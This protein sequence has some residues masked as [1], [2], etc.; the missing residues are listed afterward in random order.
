ME[1]GR[2][3]PTHPEAEGEPV[4]RFS[5]VLPVCHGGE[6]LRRSVAA[7]CSLDWTP[8]EFEVL[9]AGGDGARAAVS[10]TPSPGPPLRHV[11]CESPVRA[12]LLNAACTE[13]QGAVLVFVD[14]DARAAPDLLRRL[15]ETLEAHPDAGIVG[16]VDELDPAAGAFDVT[17]DCVFTSFVGT[18]GCRTGAGARIGKYYPKLWNMAVPRPAAEAVALEGGK[19][20]DESLTVHEDVDLAE[21]VERAGWRIVFAPAMRVVHRRE[22]TYRSVLRRNA[23]MAGVCRT[24]GLH[25]TVHLLAAVGLLVILVLL[26][27]TPWARAV[28]MPLGI[29]LAAYAVLLLAVGIRAAC[30]RRC[31][32]LLVL[33]PFLAASLH[34]ARAL[35]YLLPCRGGRRAWQD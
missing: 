24:R 19:L 25:R 14:D 21:R 2:D 18:G 8:G 30:R 5:L 20:F 27:L 34:L 28:R 17:L 3:K 16:G 22:T 32:A 26:A 29:L 6:L 10:A 35:G 23:A 11:E 15:A 9:V 13:A 7:A 31:P 4:I 1:L 33:V 12:A